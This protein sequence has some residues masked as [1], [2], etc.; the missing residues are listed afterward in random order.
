VRAWARCIARAIRAWGVTS[1][2]RSCRPRWPLTPTGCAGS[3]QEARAAAAL[4]HPNILSVHDVGADNGVAYLVT[5]LLEGRTLR[6]EMSEKTSGPDVFSVLD[7]AVQIAEGLAAA[8]ARSIVHRD[9]KPE[10]VFVTTDG[11]VKILDFGL[12]KVLEA[13]AH[14]GRT[15]RSA[16]SGGAE[17]PPYVPETATASGGASRATTNAPARCQ[18]GGQVCEVPQRQR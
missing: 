5:E 4:N 17:A 10:N 11:R 9:L 8:H 13:D 16:E 6:E 7:Y 1:R 15:F 12:A 14:V 18:S 2:S 3:E